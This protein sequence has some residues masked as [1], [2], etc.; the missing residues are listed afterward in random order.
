V[1][2][3]PSETGESG[4]AEPILKPPFADLGAL[5]LVRLRDMRGAARELFKTLDLFTREG[6]HPVGDLFL[7]AKEPFTTFMRYPSDGVGD[8]EDRFAW[9][10]HAHD[11]SADRPWGEN[12]HFHCFAYTE[13]M[14]PTASPWALPPTPDLEAGGLIHLVAVCVNEEGV[15]DRLFTLN[16]WASDEWLYRSGDVIPLI[17]RFRVS[18][19]PRFP[20]T[21]RWLSALLRLLQ[22]QI[23]WLLQERD[24]VLKELCNH[25]P[26]SFSEDPSVEVASTLTF[27]LDRHLA[28][29]DFARKGLGQQRSKS[30]GESP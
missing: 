26:E 9:Y 28:A 25:H 2:R 30:P 11:P 3:R 27:D 17:E 22:P 10:Y 21:S 16:R 7:A 18:H 4:L 24:A 1:G 6:R 13:A 20:L 5:P 29:L 15:P 19:D 12:G 23:A 14:G 8:A